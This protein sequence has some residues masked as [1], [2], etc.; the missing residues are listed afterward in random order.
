MLMLIVSPG[1]PMSQWPP[2]LQSATLQKGTEFLVAT[3][4]N[5]LVVEQSRLIYAQ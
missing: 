1:E 4:L 5:V 2:F 3:I